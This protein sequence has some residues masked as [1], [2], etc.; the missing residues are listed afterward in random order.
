[1]GQ[2]IIRKRPLQSYDSRGE[3]PGSS[4]N[5]NL[6]RKQEPIFEDSPGGQSA[7]STSV[8]K[9]IENSGRDDQYASTS[10]CKF[11]NQDFLNFVENLKSFNFC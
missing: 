3:N 1:M 2:C 7:L 9:T 8:T 6:T 4:L 5:S 11:T 10:T